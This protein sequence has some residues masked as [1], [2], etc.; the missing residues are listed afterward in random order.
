[1][2]IKIPVYARAFVDNFT[3]TGNTRRRYRTIQ[4]VNHPN[5]PDNLVTT[6]FVNLAIKRIMGEVDQKAQKNTVAAMKSMALA[7][8]KKAK[9]YVPKDTRRLDKSARVMTTG[10]GKQREFQVRF[11]TPYAL[12]VHEDPNAHHEPP[13]QYKYLEQATSDVV[14][15]R[16]G[17]KRQTGFELL[18]ERPILNEEGDINQFGA[19]EIDLGGL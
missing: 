1:M 5:L 16:R 7:I 13:T 6:A 11:A 12:Y 9:Y 19:F 17:R 14:A 8:K 4:D 2:S 15:D 3:A 18:E 10:R